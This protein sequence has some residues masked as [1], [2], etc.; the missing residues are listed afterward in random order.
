MLSLL[1]MCSP[2][3][4]IKAFAHKELHIFGHMRRRYRSF[5]LSTTKNLGNFLVRP[6]NR[7]LS[8]FILETWLGRYG[9][10][11]DMYINALLVI[12]SQKS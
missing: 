9:A 11:A 1:Y 5:N 12:T 2:C 7:P 8:K 10:E 3:F 6:S 4:L